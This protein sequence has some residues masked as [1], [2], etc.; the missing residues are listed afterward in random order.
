MVN[1]HRVCLICWLLCVSP[2]RW[3]EN[4]LQQNIW[5]NSKA[6]CIHVNFRSVKWGFGNTLPH[7]FAHGI[8]ATLVSLSHC[9]TNTHDLS[10]SPPDPNVPLEMRISKTI[11][12]KI[13]NDRILHRSKL[14]MGGNFHL[15]E[16]TGLH[17]RLKVKCEC[18]HEGITY[19]PTD[20]LPYC[21]MQPHLRSTIVFV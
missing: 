9:V 13:I 10:L 1:Y 12:K 20:I 14:T 4:T 18:Y 17:A 3:F 11:Y 21:R 16:Y 5:F 6:V 7:Q 15:K 2:K 8:S 19:E